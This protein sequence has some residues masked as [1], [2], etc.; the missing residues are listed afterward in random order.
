MLPE[1]GLD[2]YEGEGREEPT[3]PITLEGWKGVGWGDTAAKRLAK[4]RRLNRTSE[5]TPTT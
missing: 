1:V 4:T 2:K 3:G 5:E